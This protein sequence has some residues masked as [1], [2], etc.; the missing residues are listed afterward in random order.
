MISVTRLLGGSS[1]RVGNSSRVRGNREAAKRIAPPVVVWSAT[2]TCNFSCLHCQSA[3]TD[4]RIPGEL[5][6]TEARAMIDDLVLLGVSS[7]IV[8]GGEPLIREDVQE[9]VGRAA[10]RGIHVGL[11]TNGSLLTPAVVAALAEMGVRDVMV[12]ICGP[13]EIH[14]RFRLQPGAYRKAVEGIRAARRGGIRV[15]VRFTVTG[16]NI[17]DLPRVLQLVEE[18]E[19]SSVEIHHLVYSQRGSVLEGVDLSHPEARDVTETVIAQADR[20]IREGREI[21]V[22]T[23]RSDFDGPFLVL[24]L[25]EHDSSRT[26]AAIEMLEARGGNDDGVRNAAIDSFGFVHPD[27]C[28]SDLVIGSIRERP[29]S[30]IWRDGSNTLLRDLR[31]RRALLKGRCA[32]C[33]WLDVCNGGVRA[34]ASAT[35][36]DLW[37]EDPACYLQEEEML[38]ARVSA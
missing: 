11:A 20:W 22:R 17:D 33:R 37:Q 7:L 4:Q 5:S 34:R 26:A 2:Q 24:W 16:D 27:W 28:G 3:A 19:L 18:E 8:T 38:V 6:T 13:E 10:A 15:G 1:Q 14:D 32:T 31:D 35:S 12:S 25:Y 30:E 21:D 9:L 36:G 23:S 29:F